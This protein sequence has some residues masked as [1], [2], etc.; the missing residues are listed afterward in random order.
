MQLCE[1]VRKTKELLQINNNNNN[2]NNK[3]TTKKTLQLIEICAPV[4]DPK[5][6]RKQY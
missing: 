1:G 6:E 2:S 5:N 3:N 4:L